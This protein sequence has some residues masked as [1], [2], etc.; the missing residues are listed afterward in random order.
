MRMP[1]YALAYQ[2]IPKSREYALESLRRFETALMGLEP[3]LGANA[4]K[5][6]GD[7]GQPPVA[8]ATLQAGPGDFVV[9]SRTLSALR[10]GRYDGAHAFLS[11]IRDPALRGQVVL[12]VCTPGDTRLSGFRYGYGAH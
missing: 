12:V 5:I 6:R 4:S 1:L 8:D 10:A 3:A 11:N 2:M 7:L 9:V